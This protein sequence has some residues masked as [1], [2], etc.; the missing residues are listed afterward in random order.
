MFLFLESPVVK[1]K[2]KHIAVGKSTTNFGIDCQATGEAPLDVQWYH[3]GAPVVKDG[4]HIILP[5][6]TLLVL[7]VSSPNDLGNYMCVASNNLGSANRT[8]VGMS[9]N[10]R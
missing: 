5:D 3:N 7:G 8:A 6:R 2:T 1:I 10:R 4:K 9:T